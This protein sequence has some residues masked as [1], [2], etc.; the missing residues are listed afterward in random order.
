M[1]KASEVYDRYEPLHL[2]LISVVGLA[3]AVG[4]AAVL[5]PRRVYDAFLWRY[6]F[7]PVV[8]DAHGAACALRVDRHT[9]LLDTSRACAE[10][11]G[12]VAFP[13]YTTVSTAT[14][15]V[16]LLL[17]L[18]GVYFALERFEAGDNPGFFYALVPFMLFGGVLRTLEDANIALLREGLPAIIPFPWSGLIISPFIYFTVFVIALV[19]FLATASAERHGLIDRYEPALAGVGSVVLVA[20]VGYLG[21]LALTTPAVGFNPLVLL[22]VIGGATVITVLAWVGVERYAP[23]VNEGTG[24]MG[25]VVVWGHT[26]DGI[27][28]VLSLDW[29]HVFGLPAYAPK[30][31]VNDAIITLAT[32]V[33]PPEVTAVI[34]TAWPFLPLKIVV[35]LVVVWIFDPE[36]F[37]DNPR[38]ATLLLV[39]VLAV[40]VGPGTRDMLRATLGI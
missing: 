13:G 21:W 23:S 28:N 31:V 8:A 18:F 20:A 1:M 6:F 40:G 17:A 4:V 25:A 5:F 14:Y 35:A 26:L 39:A 34:G 22:I 7:G 15:A 3:V 36:L 9:E 32:R 16:V 19:A 24:L 12:I 30:H 11:V 27:A 2:W 10:A 33:Q 38:F 37:E 29:G